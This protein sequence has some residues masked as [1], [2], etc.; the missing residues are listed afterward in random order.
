MDKAKIIE[1]LRAAICPANC[2]NGAIPHQVGEDEWGAEQCQFCHE[3]EEAIAQLEQAGEAEP[4]GL[5]DEDSEGLYARIEMEVDTD[6]VLWHYKGNAKAGDKVY[7]A[8]PA[9]P[10]GVPDLSSLKR[11]DLDSP[12]GVFVTT[13]ENDDG[14]LVRFADVAELLNTSPVQANEI[15]QT[16]IRAWKGPQAPAAPATKPD[17]D[18]LTRRALAL[19]KPPFNFNYGYIFDGDHNTVADSGGMDELKNMIISRVRGWGRICYMD[20]PE[21][22]QDKVGELVAVALTEYWERNTAPQPEQENI[23]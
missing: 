12:D 16:L 11:F 4:V 5:L 23:K 20:E 1:L 13:V 3:R 9:Q 15:E 10:A 22:L 17:P 14:M 19:Y 8:P 7:L 21:K 6:G 18:E 2:D